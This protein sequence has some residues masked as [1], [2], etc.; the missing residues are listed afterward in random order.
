MK[1]GKKRKEKKK[2]GKKRKFCGNCRGRRDQN[3][4]KRPIE[5]LEAGSKKKKEKRKKTRTLYRCQKFQHPTV[6]TSKSYI[7]TRRIARNSWS[8][9][10][11]RSRDTDWCYID[12]DNGLQTEFTRC[13]KQ[14]TLKKKDCLLSENALLA[15][16]TDPL[17]RQ[18]H[19]LGKLAKQTGVTGSS[20]SWILV[21][22]IL[23][24]S[25]LL[26]FHNNFIRWGKKACL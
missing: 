22:R 2:G 13:Q 23:W 10:S 24:I 19:S 7:S 18:F 26:H 4:D 20:E 1:K 3:A 6:N 9:L 21:D 16:A 12:R 17:M 25:A 5:T 8:R 11:K 15:I 14:P